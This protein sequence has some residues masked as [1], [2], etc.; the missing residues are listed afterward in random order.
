LKRAGVVSVL[1]HCCDIWYTGD[2]VSKITWSIYIYENFSDNHA[3]VSKTNTRVLLI[4]LNCRLGIVTWYIDWL[5]H[6]I[7]WLTLS[8][9]ILIDSVTWYIDWLCHLIYWLTLLLDILIDSVTW[10]ID[11][12]VYGRWRATIKSTF[13]KL[14]FLT[15]VVDGI[16]YFQTICNFIIVF[17]CRLVT[18]G[19]IFLYIILYVFIFPICLC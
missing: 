10:Y 2:S 7:Y 9:D 12:L 11:W 4:M 13:L 8:L 16:S 19:V 6:L 14:L 18:I 5:C 3:S 15:W 17:L 1:K